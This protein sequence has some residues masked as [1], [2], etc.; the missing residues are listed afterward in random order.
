M[1]AC[2]AGIRFARFAMS[3]TLLAVR[4]ECVMSAVSP[5][6]ARVTE[7]IRDRSTQERSPYLTRVRAAQSRQPQRSGH[8]CANLAHGFAA[9][10]DADK[11]MLLDLQPVPNIGIVSAYNDILS[12]HQPLGAYPAILKDEIRQAGAVGQFAGGVPAMGD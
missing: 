12:A 2:A 4:E 7:R 9:A 11:G 6:I 1:C 3:R 5:V 8:A 10:S